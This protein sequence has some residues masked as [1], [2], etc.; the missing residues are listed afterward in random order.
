MD[1][2]GTIIV[3]LGVR[4]VRRSGNRRTEGC[5]LFWRKRAAHCWSAHGRLVYRLTRSR[6]VDAGLPGPAPLRREKGSVAAFHSVAVTTPADLSPIHMQAAHLA[7][8][9][10]GK[11]SQAGHDDEC[12]AQPKQHFKIP[13]FFRVCCTVL[14]S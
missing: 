11:E 3:P 13:Y 5:F 10:Q 6:N 14:F 7:Q 8:K 9:G 12:T 2:D 1:E 4:L